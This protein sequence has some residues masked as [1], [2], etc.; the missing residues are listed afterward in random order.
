MDLTI[1]ILACVACF[2]VILA[3]EFLAYIW[4]RYIAH[5]NIIMG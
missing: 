5:E 3:S 4:H 1:Y 2:M